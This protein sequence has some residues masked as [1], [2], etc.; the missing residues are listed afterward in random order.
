[1]TSSCIFCKIVDGRIPCYQVYEDVETLAFLD[2]HPWSLGHTLIIP[3]KHFATLDVCPPKTMAAIARA[4]PKIAQAIMA[5]TETTAF[6]VLNNNRREAGQL[7]DHIHFHIV[8]RVADDRIFSHGPQGEY[9]ENQAEALARAIQ[10][11]IK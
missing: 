4:M 9:A 3:K 2:I 7:V 8:P 10:A 1:M 11:G 5:A 6:N